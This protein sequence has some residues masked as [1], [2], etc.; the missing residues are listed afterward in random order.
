MAINIL[1]VEWNPSAS[2]PGGGKPPVG[3]IGT[4]ATWTRPAELI[5]L[6]AD[7]VWD[8]Q[9][10][11]TSA[12]VGNMGVWPSNPGSKCADYGD[13]GWVWYL[14]RGSSR[15]GYPFNGSVHNLGIYSGR[16]NIALADGHVKSMSY[17]V[18]EGCNF[19]PSSNVWAYSYWDPRY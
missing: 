18:L 17:N 3:P 12:G 11:A 1:L 5:L 7:S 6:T 13:P 16:A 9:G 4:M 8:T 19:V 14:H 15:S 2:W 10:D